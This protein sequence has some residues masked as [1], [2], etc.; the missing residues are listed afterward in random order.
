MAELHRRTRTSHRRGFVIES[1]RDHLAT[2][3][4]TEI[5]PDTE[6]ATDPCLGL[7]DIESVASM[8]KANEKRR[9]SSPRAFTRSATLRV[10][11]LCQTSTHRD[12][13][14]EQ[15][16]TPVQAPKSALPD[17]AMLSV[18]QF[19]TSLTRAHSSVLTVQVEEIDV[20]IFPVPWLK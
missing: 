9:I 5:L 19:Q 16:R 11:L 2:I 1:L 15:T 7:G 20:Q 18:L 4:S 8:A 12:E 6:L 14:P 10:H 13:A 17:W 3:T